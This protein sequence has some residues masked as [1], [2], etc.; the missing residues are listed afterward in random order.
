MGPFEM[1][2]AIVA[3]AAVAGIIKARYGITKDAKGNEIRIADTGET[4]ALQ[5]EIRAL[6]DRIQVL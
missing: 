6:K 3:I 1:V 5:S 4:K 2:V